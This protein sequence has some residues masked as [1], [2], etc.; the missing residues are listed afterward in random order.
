MIICRFLGGLGNQLF[1]YAAAR[2]LANRCRSE[3]VADSRLFASYKLHSYLIDRFPVRMVDASS[4]DLRGMILPPEK[5]GPV[6]WLYWSVRNRGRLNVFREKT[7]RYQPQFEDLADNTYL[8]GYWQSEKYFRSIEPLLREELAIP[9]PADEA[10]Q[11]ALKQIR[12]E[13]SVSLHIRR[14]DYVSNSKTNQIHGTCSLDYYQE[15]ARFMADQSGEHPVF[16]VFSDDSVWTRENLKLP[17]P[18]KFMSHNPVDVPLADLK[19]MSSCRHH[20]IA[21]SSFSWWG[22]WLNPSPEKTVIA[23]RTWF[24]DPGRDD[25]DIVPDSWH[26]IGP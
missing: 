23:C 6:N 17:F 25:R 22:A 9:E 8:W 21:N 16:F 15:A 7:L 10:N 24:A 2:S 13:L 4:A 26:R 19:L 18:M 14:G 11:E 3:V 5:R 12:S 20:V 1:Q